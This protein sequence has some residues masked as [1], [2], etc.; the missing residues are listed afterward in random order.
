VEMWRHHNRKRQQ[1]YAYIPASVRNAMVFSWGRATVNGS[2]L[3]NGNNALAIFQSAIA[4]SN[5]VKATST[6]LYVLV[7]RL[8]SDRLKFHHIMVSGT[9]PNCS[10]A[11]RST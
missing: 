10:S 3:V 1:R 11:R 5:F 8:L 6:P 4:S 9:V 7:L 2:Y